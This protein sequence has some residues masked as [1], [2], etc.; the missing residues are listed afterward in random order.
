MGF[1]WG[2]PSL[3]AVPHPLPWPG[4]CPMLGSLAGC[5]QQSPP[6]GLG[7][8]CDS[9]RLLGPGP[10]DSHLGW[11]NGAGGQAD[12]E[13]EQEA[14]GPDLHAQ[15]HGAVCPSSCPAC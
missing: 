7:L 6:Q 11:E 12:E 9:G 10:S 3:H 1:G 4:L 8:L 5:P 2:P 14:G 15:R 13:E